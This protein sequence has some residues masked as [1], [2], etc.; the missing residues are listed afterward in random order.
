MDFPDRS[1]I[2]KRFEKVSVE[3]SDYQTDLLNKLQGIV[4]KA[5]VEKWGDVPDIKIQ[6][7]EKQ[8]E[9]FWI[10]IY[11]KEEDDKLN[12]GDIV[13]LTHTP[14]NEK[15]D[16]IFGAYE[17]EGLNRDYTDE[18]INYSTKDDKKI[19]CCMIDLDRVNKESDDI[20]KLRTF[21][22]NSRYYEENL[23][24]KT[25]IKVESGD[26]EYEYSSIS[27]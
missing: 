1:E 27:F 18:V 6:Q 21:F 15:I 20:P 26:K 22:R 8:K 19:L 12:K 9:Y 5:D 2:K 14:T 11:L 17:K 4:E 24:F 16:M 7:T 3:T 23:F 10:R 25:D 13:T